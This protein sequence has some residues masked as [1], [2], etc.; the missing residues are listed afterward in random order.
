MSILKRLPPLAIPL[1]LCISPVRA[2]E[3]ER[4]SIVQLLAN[5]QAYEGKRVEVS[6]FVNIEFE[7]NAI[8]LHKE[9]FMRGLYQNALWL[10]VSE[11]G[12]VDASGMP[13]SAYASLSG[14]FT[15]KLHGHMGLWPAQI[16]LTGSCF[17]LPART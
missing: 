11:G 15:A 13:L 16:T 12:C 17:P 5:P 4:V 3:V 9:D 1:L 10:N 7:G 6:G 14:T 8:W 2:A